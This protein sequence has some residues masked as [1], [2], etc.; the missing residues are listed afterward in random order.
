MSIA[1]LDDTGHKR[2]TAEQIFGQV[3]AWLWF[4]AGLLLL[5]V[6]GGNRALQ[7][8]DTYW[9]IVVGQWIIDHR[10]LPSVDVYSFGVMLRMAELGARYNEVSGTVVCCLFYFIWCL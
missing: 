7:D 5:F 2:S 10:A 8:A 9:Q 4:G 6:I 3:P 1:G